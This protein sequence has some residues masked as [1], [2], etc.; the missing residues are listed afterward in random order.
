MLHFLYFFN[1]YSPLVRPLKPIAA[2]GITG[3][4]P[5]DSSRGLKL[6]EFLMWKTFVTTPTVAV[7]SVQW[8]AAHLLHLIGNGV[9][10]LTSVK[11]RLNRSPMVYI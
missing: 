1:K 10:L 5:D 3:E 11:I 8:F 2:Q 6:S 7:G 4:T 9:Q